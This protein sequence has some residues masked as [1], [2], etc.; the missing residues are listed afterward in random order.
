MNIKNRL[1]VNYHAFVLLRWAAA[2]RRECFYVDSHLILKVNEGL[3]C[4]VT[5]TGVQFIPN[6]PENCPQSNLS[7]K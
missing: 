1:E 6:C 7:D 5:I 4:Q 3:G 2:V